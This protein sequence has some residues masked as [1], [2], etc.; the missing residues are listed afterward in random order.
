[1]KKLIY[2]CFL[3]I[4]VSLQA[5]ITSTFDSNADGWT[6]FD[7]SAVTV[8]HIATGGNPNGYAT[9]GYN[10][11]ILANQFWRAPSKFLG[12]QVARSLGMN[13]RFDM[14]VSVTGTNSF[15]Q[16][17]V[18]ITNGGSSLAYSLPS[19][20]GT[21][22]TSYSLRLDETLG[23][24]IGNTSGALATRT[25]IISVLSNITE[26]TLRGTFA[27]FS[28]NSSSIDNVIM[29]QRTFSP[30][31]ISSIT[32]SAALPGTV[33]T[34]TGNNFDP[35]T[36]NNA[37]YVGHVRTTITNASAT[38]LSILVPTNAQYGLVTVVNKT[39]GLAKQ[40]EQ[41][42]NPLFAGGGRIIPS[43]FKANFT[44][45][46]TGGFGG[47]SLTDMDNDGWTDIV[48]AAQD[49]SAIR[50]YRN[51]ALGGTLSISSFA[52]SVSFATTL[53]GTNGAGLATID[54]DND[55]KID[56]ATS[57]WTGGPGA[58]AT[59]RN[60]ST[61][62]NLAFE[63]VE[64]W[65]GI[66]DE[67][68]VNAA[69]DIDGDGLVDLVSG[70]GSS[71][72]AT[73]IIQNIS[74][75]GNIEFGVSRA[76]FGNNS[77]Q[78]A[79]L[80]DLNGDGKPEFILK[81]Q[82][83]L[84]QQDIYTNTSTPGT[85][86]FGSSFTLP[87]GIQGSMIVFDFNKDGKN[88]LAWKDGFSSND[89]RIRINTNTGGPLSLADF[90][91][92][93]ILDSETS[94]YGGASLGD[95]NGDGKPDILATDSDTPAVFESVFS[96]G[97]F[98][99]NA[100]IPAHRFPGIGSF[101]YPFAPQAGDLN[102]DGKPD[103]VVGF[104][105]SS[106]NKIAIYE[107][108]NVAS[109]KI[110]V[111]TVSPLA[112]PIGSTVTITGSGFSPNTA[113]NFVY[114]GAVQAASV[115]TASSTSL[116][117]L[118]PI[119]ASY[120]PVRVRVG[121]LSSTYH[122]PF[123]TTFSTGVTFNSTHFAPPV[124]FALANP[125]YHIDVADIDTDGKPDIAAETTVQRPTF[126][127]NTH[128]LGAITTSSLT[129]AGTTAT[130][131]TDGKFLDVDGNGL[132]E[133]IGTNGQM[134]PNNSTPSSISFGSGV[135]LTIGASS[136]AF[137]DINLDGKIELAA[138]ETNRLIVLENRSSSG[139]IS[140][141]GVFGSFANSIAFNKPA[142]GG[143][144]VAA[145][146]DADGYPDVIATNPSTN[147]LSIFPNNK[148]PRVNSSSFATRIDIASG[149]NPIKAY[150]GDFDSDGKLDFVI[151]YGTGANLPFVSVFHNLSTPGS[152]SFNRVDFTTPD[153]QPITMLTVADLDGDGK[154]EIATTHESANR[155]SIFK[156]VHT[157][158]PIITSSFAIPLSTS[159][160]APRGI[161][162]VD[163]NGDG[164][165]EIVL[166]QNVSGGQL[167]VYQNL[168][169]NP[170]ITSFLP[171]SGTIG[172]Q[173][174][175]SG[176]NFSTTPTENEVKFNGITAY[177]ISSTATS[178]TAIVPP[179][180]V[181][182]PVSVTVTNN[183]A[184]SA[185]NFTV[186]PF[187]CPPG[188]PTG[189]S[190]DTS[191]DPLVQS[192]VTFD[193]V[194]L[195]STGKSLVSVPDVLIGGFTRRG[196]LR[197]NTD[198]T[199]DGTFAIN[200]YSS[201]ANQLI[202][203]PDDKIILFDNDEFA[204]IKRLTVDGANDPA[205]AGPVF[206][207]SGFYTT[208]VGPLE[209]QSDGKVL[210]SSYNTF[211]FV[212]ELIRLNTDGSVDAS[213]NAPSDLD[214]LAIRQ[215][216]DGK[217]I[218]GGNFGITRLTTSG[219]VDASFI[220]S[221]MDGA[222]YDIILQ[223]DNKIIIIGTFTK[224]LGV[225][226]RNIA[227]L[228]PDGSV[229][230]TF[231]SGNGFSQYAGAQPNIVKLLTDGKILVGGEFTSYNDVTRNRLVM[232]N[233][234]GSLECAFD[235]LGGPSGQLLDVA[236]QADK[237]ILIVGS[238]TAYNGTP[239]NAFA[240]VNGITASCVP[241]IQRAALIALYNATNGASWTNN[242]NWLSADESTWHGITITGCNVTR[243]DL[244]GNN[245]LGSLP[246]E[247][248]NLTS[249]THLNLGQNGISTNVLS[250]AIP[251][252]IGNLT[253]LQ[254]LYLSAKQLSGLLPASIGN[255]TSLRDLDLGD[256]QFT[257]NIPSSWFNLTQLETLILSRNSLS[258]TL[259]PQ[260]GQLA[261]LKTLQIGTNQ[262]SGSLP[263][264]IGNL[265][266]LV[267][268]VLDANQFTGSIPSSFGNLTNMQFFGCSVNQLSGNLPASLSNLSNLVTFVISL[269]QFTG[270][271]PA[272][273]GT[274]PNLFIVN[275]RGNQ[276]TSIP[277][278]VSTALVDLR[279]FDN[280]LNFGH[281]EPN[282][283]K[284][285]FVYSP[286]GNLPGG[287]TS[288]CTGSTLTINF[289]TPG[290][291]NQ[292][293]WFKDGVLIPGATS[294][295]FTKSNAV[296]GDAG[297]YTVRVTNTIVTGLTLNSDPFVV[298]VS[299]LPTPPSASGVSV[300][301]GNVATLTAS[302]GASGQYRWY[303]VPVGGTAV[304]GQTNSTFVASNISVIT[305]FYVSLNNGTCEST[306]TAVAVTPISTACAPPAIAT[307]NISISIGDNKSL[308]LKT[309]ITTTGGTL[310]VNSISV[311]IPPPSGAIATI[312]GGVLT[313]DYKG[314]AFAGKEKITIRA[315]D[316]NGNCS[317]QQIEIEVVGEIVVYNAVSP[318]GDGKNEF[319]V[320]QYIES[321]SP[322]NQ[323]SIYN[324]WGDEVFSISDYDN[325]TR[326]F[327]GI[328][329]GG[330]KLPVGT[331][332]YKIVLADA[333]K[334]ITGFIS[335][336]H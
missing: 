75:P 326:V 15:T 279:V 29:E 78:G 198:G 101:T 320:L 246:A 257:G 147:N 33:V 148:A 295:T 270:D 18:V 167:V 304:A 283:G 43:S 81:I 241:A 184:I 152:F 191:F 127:R 134:F 16:G 189:G 285:G 277:P 264:E 106:P 94:N 261:A 113:E 170:N 162:T 253:N 231:N 117:A 99:A 236:V 83:A 132:A 120:A 242:A 90:S 289:S 160:T 211:N 182:G 247:I 73:W 166:T 74:T 25:Q 150:T 35:A 142:F 21:T 42:F 199:L 195:Q 255:L 290:T 319:L 32:P 45:D 112:A 108:Q 335:L 54:F 64:K 26:I 55:G 220:A 332:F 224:V 135:S 84:N 107:N 310:D 267:S 262:F 10:S 154:P 278:F 313:L 140:P 149:V 232:L 31:I 72:G 216:S 252:S 192:A 103:M 2:C 303:T 207:N 165:P 133:V 164:K 85:I 302:G 123:K 282:I 5:Q 233:A 111:T 87:L 328:S 155:F 265:T 137:A 263:P 82:N 9:A 194:E 205:F 61:P 173:V 329:S 298:T 300:C 89:I 251:A 294:A 129:T 317:T 208:Q 190:L 7:P 202:V 157:T 34:I 296:T 49:N 122:L 114:F 331:Y 288:A 240:R 52:A 37:V 248:G 260:I 56:M 115:L 307:A 297:D 322:K 196:L 172:T 321:I 203:Q 130:A 125:T 27:S 30:P 6:F 281:L 186:I 124:S 71:P 284:T 276:F 171:V 292:Y 175:I 57:G 287:V 139:N 4:S 269:N 227:R 17:D 275:V 214:A 22:W 311:T 230:L 39:T 66:T 188:T 299:A 28:P 226:M 193:A 76:F 316:S 63:T 80:G 272:A 70:E 314:V 12:N 38:S 168:I 197:F 234:N 93:I 95:I 334:P 312:T 183:T 50:V 239:R 145:D 325:K 79:T 69:V 163:I 3:S 41:R 146:F 309:L 119:G 53:S 318:N 88:D 62:S 244:G 305:T 259:S 243:I 58:F 47:M 180:T 271:L 36:A 143:G 136:S 13:F 177:V 151:H 161:N 159:L 178:I 237:K 330:S 210:Y 268:L 291:A 104:T 286:Q 213:F 206:D 128:L 67:S 51:L 98:D 92:E 254:V 323:V 249:L 225:P 215:Q 336:K 201:A 158:G 274:F 223:P 19:K 217:I 48:V 8:F 293:Q 176:T 256:N 333:S 245:M 266:Q 324:R 91:T 181:T 228:L 238:L 169:A 221:S 24:R 126:F 179:G 315:C 250:G 280:R 1:V 301:P 118:V 235:P 258:G 23:W 308:D 209:L 96:G 121:E 44:I 77:H 141:A 174:V 102:G 109:P 100:F 218:V 20:P 144:I 153:F 131:A 219:I 59:F 65:N 40:S 306:R 222:V 46:V 185:S 60:I 97:A 110:S 68:P 11:N 273:I 200:N 156:N 327:A 204:S 212:D 14:Q 116:T 187:S 86:S 105:N 229:D 138:V